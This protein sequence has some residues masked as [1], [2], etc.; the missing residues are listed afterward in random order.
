MIFVEFTKMH[1]ELS[2]FWEGYGWSFMPNY[3]KTEIKIKRKEGKELKADIGL[4]GYNVINKHM[5]SF[6]VSNIMN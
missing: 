2:E 3:S 4:H 1:N 6:V 5:H